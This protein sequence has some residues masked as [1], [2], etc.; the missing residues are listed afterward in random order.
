MSKAHPSPPTI[1]N[2]ALPRR[3]DPNQSAPPRSDLLQAEL[4]T[5]DGTMR[6]LNKIRNGTECQTRMSELRR[7]A[8]DILSQQ[9]R[10][11][12]DYH[13]ADHQ[14]DQ[15]SARR[16]SVARDYWAAMEAETRRA[17]GLD[18]EGQLRVRKS[19][20]GK[21]RT[22]TKSKSSPTAISTTEWRAL[23]KHLG[24]E[25]AS[26]LIEERERPGNWKEFV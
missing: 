11:E 4:D 10:L 2:S 18:D 19:A 12:K 15:L 20:N 1:Y 7:Q 23:V 17:R 3:P 24:V 6:Y 14:L 5:I 16:E 21:T 9:R 13:T 25:A 22:K 8:E 26:G